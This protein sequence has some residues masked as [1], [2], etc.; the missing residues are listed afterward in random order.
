MKHMNFL[1]KIKADL[2]AQ[3]VADVMKK[4]ID[5]FAS[6]VTNFHHFMLLMSQ[7]NQ[8]LFIGWKMFGYEKTNN[9]CCNS[10][11]ITSMSGMVSM[12]SLKPAVKFHISFHFP[13]STYHCQWIHMVKNSS[14]G[15][16]FVE[17]WFC[18]C[19]NTDL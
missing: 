18:Y 9:S 10:M 14:R 19:I 13:L 7:K 3:Q 11:Q 12:A 1:L 17:P 2:R 15:L 4:S 16:F 5:S 8:W 6:D